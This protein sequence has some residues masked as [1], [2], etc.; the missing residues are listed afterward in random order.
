MPNSKFSLLKS[1][2][3][4]ILAILMGNCSGSGGGSPAPAP[5]PVQPPPPPS[6]APTSV[7][8]SG[9]ISFESVGVETQE[10]T[11][12]L[13][14]LT[15]LPARGVLVEAV[16]AGGAVLASTS[17]DSTGRYTL[18]VD[19]NI[20]VQ[21]RARAKLLQDTP[22]SA[23]WDVTVLDNTNSDAEYVLAGSLQNSG[24]ANSTRNLF[25]PSGSDGVSAYTGQRVAGPFAILDAVF[26]TL[27]LFESIDSTISFEELQILWS[28]DNRRINDDEEVDRT[29]G[30]LRSSSFTILNGVP[31]I[32]ILGDT[33]TDSDEYDEHVIVHEFGHFFQ[34]SLSRDDSVGGSHSLTS[35]LDPRVSFSEG[36]GNAFSAIVLNDSLYVDAGFGDDGGFAFNIELN[37]IG[38]IIENDLGIPAAGWY[39]ESSVQSIILDIFDARNDGAD[40]ISV[41]FEPI[42]D[43]LV[44]AAFTESEAATTIY[45]FLDALTADPA[46]S[47]DAI[48]SLT[49]FQEF[50]GTGEF[51]EGETNDGGV[52][53]SLP[54]FPNYRVGDPAI[55]ICS[56]DDAD[57]FNRIGNRVLISLDVPSAGGRT[58][59]MTRISG[60]SDRN[61][62]FFIFNQGQFVTSGTSQAVDTEQQFRLLPAGRLLVDAHDDNNLE[63]DDDDVPGD[64]CYSFSVQ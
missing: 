1:G 47:S 25:A 54:V 19:P 3:V 12:D 34:R 36:F 58:I 61:P 23:M 35:L 26:E 53:S 43:V 39:G 60:D 27:I 17:T 11:L 38:Q 5:P 33:A 29:T 22:G 32:T 13:A 30:A 44:S 49:D 4:F 16:N 59:T 50:F 7:D 9:I 57:T 6:A 8:I 37:T 10:F 48:T 55:T 18:T 52:Q 41:G 20:T 62:N 2:A 56:V 45:S 63:L 14:N 42:Y 24:A 31:S 40:T 21:I 46:V 15:E 28:V 51:G 64:A